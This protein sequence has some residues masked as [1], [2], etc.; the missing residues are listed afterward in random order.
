MTRKASAGEIV[1]LKGV[2]RSG[3][4]TLLINTIKSLQAGGTPP[5]EILYVNLE[6][7]RFS[8]DLRPEFLQEIKD[9]FLEYLAPRRNPWI[10][11][12]EIQNVA[13]VEK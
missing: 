10:F 7:P 1:V 6:D 9:T 8:G 12:D 2:R 13:G 3:K 11:L 4:S 5:E